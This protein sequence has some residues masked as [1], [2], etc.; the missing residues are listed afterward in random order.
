ML[1]NEQGWALAFDDQTTD[2]SVAKVIPYGVGGSFTQGAWLQEDPTQAAV[3]AEDLPYPE[4][5]VVQFQKLLVNGA[6]P[7]LNL[8]D[9]RVLSATNGSIF[10]PTAVQNAA[11]TFDQPSGVAAQYM[12]DADTLDAALA[13]FEAETYSWNVVPAA[14]K[15]RY[16][17]ALSDAYKNDA[18]EL[19]AQSWPQS[20]NPDISLLAQRLLQVV[21]D[22]KVWAASGLKLSGPAFSA[23]ENDQRVGPLADEARATLG[24]P[25]S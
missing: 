6:P 24:L 17:Q 7:Q 10:V 20:T 16:V 22:L 18:T 13:T 3:T 14:T 2:F 1:R 4:M 23:L 8:A 12:A 21:S 9:G 19:M 25:P 5:S 11:F 15:T